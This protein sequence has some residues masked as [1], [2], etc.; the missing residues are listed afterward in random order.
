MKVTEK[1]KFKRKSIKKKVMEFKKQIWLQAMVIPGIIFIIIFCYIPMFGVLIAFKEYNF[2][3]GFLGSPWVGLK[4]FRDFLTD[5]N[6]GNVM[7]NTIGIS[8]L[9]SVVGFPIPII[10]ALLLNELRNLRFKKTIQTVSY[11][12]HFISYVVIAGFVGKILASNGV[13]NEIL[14]ALRIIKEPILFLG[15]KNCFWGILAGTGIWKGMGYGSILYLAAITGV[16]QSMY[17]SATLDGASRLRKVI[18]ITLPSIAPIIV[19]QLIFM[20][21]GLL[22]AGFEDI[23]LLQ[24][25][26]VMERAEVLDTYVYKMGLQY[27]RFSYA[28]AVGLLTSVVRIALVLATNWISKKTTEHSMW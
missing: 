19:I 23:L 21:N 11:L 15:E 6:L 26:M 8:L 17:E 4:H 27:G 10:F 3:D 16:D 7:Y 5:P 12:P 2:A 25:S 22:S 14:M 28:T 1:E 24:N 18:S 9:K 13:V 20:V